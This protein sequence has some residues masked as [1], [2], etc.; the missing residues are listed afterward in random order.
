MF[1]KYATKYRF[2]FYK[3]IISVRS[4][5]LTDYGGEDEFLWL[6]L[7]KETLDL[8]RAIS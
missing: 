5:A 8:G 6:T 7:V 4:V 1:L 3:A 2:F